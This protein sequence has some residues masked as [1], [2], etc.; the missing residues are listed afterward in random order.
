[1][2]Q[3]LFLFGDDRDGAVEVAEIVVGILHLTHDPGLAG[4]GGL[5]PRIRRGGGDAALVRA[6]PRPR[7][8]L[9]DGQRSR[10]WPGAGLRLLRMPDDAESGIRQRADLGDPVA[11][12]LEIQ[13][14]PQESGVSTERLLDQCGQR[15]VPVGGVQ[16]F[17]DSGPRCP[18]R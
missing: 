6:L 10:L 17:L 4:P 5:V 11:L 15:R 18:G 16:R 14:R 3:Q 7:K 13:S 9:A 2:A 8:L 12:G 1:M